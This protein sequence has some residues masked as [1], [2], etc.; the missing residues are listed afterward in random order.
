[1]FKI[2]ELWTVILWYEPNPRARCAFGNVFLYPSI[3]SYTVGRFLRAATKHVICTCGWSFIFN[4]SNVHV[5]L[6]CDWGGSHL[7][8][9]MIPQS[10]EQC[11]ITIQGTNCKASVKWSLNLLDNHQ[12]WTGGG[13]SPGAIVNQTSDGLSSARSYLILCL[14]AFVLIPACIQ[15]VKW[16]K[17]WSFSRHR[18]R[19][20]CQT[21]SLQDLS[22]T[23]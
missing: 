20:I 17:F 22:H 18:L 3:L 16:I 15:W 2:C 13:F 1:M 19:S 9:E 8:R 23:Y 6:C 21:M 5:M 12:C 11:S 7:L 14:C 10:S 4:L